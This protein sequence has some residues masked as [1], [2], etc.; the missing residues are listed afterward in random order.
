VVVRPGAH[1]V[2]LLG[3][4]AEGVQG[5]QIARYGVVRASVS[6]ALVSAAMAC[7]SLDMVANGDPTAEHLEVYDTKSGLWHPELGELTQPDGWSFLP[8][9][10]AFLTRRV[11]AAGEYW[12]LF[13]PKGRR[14]HRRQL[15][16][17]APADAIASA[18]NRR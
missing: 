16:L 5:A 13:R 18:Q 14:E 17:L 6:W 12:V 2:A 7:K 3:D 15:G 9:G 11:K 1:S 10:D 4:A 8:A